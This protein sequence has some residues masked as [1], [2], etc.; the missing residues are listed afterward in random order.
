MV[1]VTTLPWSGPYTRADL[2]VMPDDGHRYE[3]IDGVLLVTPAPGARHQ[4]AV[5]E[6]AVLLRAA[7]PPALQVSSPRSPSRSPRTPTVGA[8]A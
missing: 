1:A 4:T 3:L 6:L 7:C 8:E 5:L 2:A